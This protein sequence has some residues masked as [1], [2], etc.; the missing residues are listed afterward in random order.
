M[1]WALFDALFIVTKVLADV[2]VALSGSAAVAEALIMT[3]GGPLGGLALSRAP[4]MLAGA[5]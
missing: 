4:T 2:T 5:M 3:L 1:Q